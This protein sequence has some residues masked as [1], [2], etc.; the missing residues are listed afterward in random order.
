MRQRSEKE[1]RPLSKRQLRRQQQEEMQK[2]QLEKAF[3]FPFC[4]RCKVKLEPAWIKKLK[5]AGSFPLCPVCY[6][7]MMEQFKKL[8]E[9]WQKFKAR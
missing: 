1:K 7:L 2:K 9:L 6:P 3:E 8:G 4:R 5:K